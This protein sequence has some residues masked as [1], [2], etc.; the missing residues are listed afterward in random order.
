MMSNKNKKSDIK[1]MSQK[2]IT[3]Q[4]QKKKKKKEEE[5]EEGIEGQYKEPQWIEVRKAAHAKIKEI[6][7]GWD[8]LGKR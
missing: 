1:I 5:E 8:N 6:P 4:G 3:K 7:L 2:K